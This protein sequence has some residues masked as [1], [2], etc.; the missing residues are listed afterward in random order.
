MARNSNRDRN[1]DLNWDYY[2]YE[3]RPRNDYYGPDY[4]GRF[5]RDYDRDNYGADTNRGNEF[6]Y[7]WLYPS[8]W[9]YN[10]YNNN[11]TNR[12]QNR[13]QY[14]GV[15]PHSYT[16]SDDRI[17]EDVNDRL[18]WDGRIDASDINVDVSDGVV[19]LTGSVDRRWD[20][21]IAEDDADDVMGVV[22]VNNQ[23]RVRN[24]NTSRSSR[25]GA[26]GEQMRTGMEVVG[27]RGA[28]IGTVKEVRDNDFLVDRSAA[29]DVY[30]PFDQCYIDGNEV[31]LYIRSDQ[32]DQQGWEMP[33]KMS[34]TEKKNKH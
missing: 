9:A 31:H 21:R 32:M 27:S 11:Y 22:D 20:K 3:Y 14:Y 18:T 4:S 28:H 13:G 6:D 26:M 29:F 12:G 33:E 23:L 17:R 2:Y 7:D 25:A 34:N 10:D 19:S 16:R 5:A 1:N 15:G 24:R 8:G 30:V